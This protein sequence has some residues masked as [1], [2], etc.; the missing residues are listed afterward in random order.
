[1]CHDNNWFSIWN[2]YVSHTEPIMFHKLQH[3]WFKYRI[4]KEILS[5][6]LIR[7]VLNSGMVLAIYTIV[8]LKTLQRY[9]SKV[10]KCSI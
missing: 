5:N 1:M 6:Q 8:L 2:A 7:T 10:Y 9:K 3:N 4:L